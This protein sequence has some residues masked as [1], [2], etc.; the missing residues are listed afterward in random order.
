M[1]LTEINIEPKVQPNSWD[2]YQML[3]PYTYSEDT[4]FDDLTGHLL[5]VL[6]VGGHERLNRRCLRFLLTEIVRVHRIDPEMCL[7]YRRHEK[8]WALL[9]GPIY[10]S[11]L[12]YNPL[13]I[14]HKCI[15]FID[16]MIA[17]GFLQHKTGFYDTFRRISR[18]SRIKPTET[19]IEGFLKA[20]GVENI[21]V[22]E[23]HL[24]PV[25][26]LKDHN[27]QLIPYD[28]NLVRDE[29][30]VLKQYNALLEDTVISTMLL[31]EK[32]RHFQK[33]VYRV[34]N[35]GSFKFGGR[36][37]GGW[38]MNCKSPF[39]KYI[40]LNT[41]PTIELDYQAQ[42]LN[43]L[44]SLEGEGYNPLTNGD[45]YVIE[46]VDRKLVKKIFLTA[47]NADDEKKGWQA[48]KTDLQFN[49]PQQL[50]EVVN[51]LSQYRQVLD[52]IKVKHPLVTSYFHSGIGLKLQNIDSEIANFILKEAVS[53]R[54]PILGVHDSFIVEDHNKGLLKD[55]M[56]G[57]YEELNISPIPAVC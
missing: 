46:G 35:N 23:S 33:F 11:E 9:N 20:W 12:S 26:E 17:K 25:I 30:E 6:D 24:R 43:L 45:P 32:H 57:A 10:N 14:S 50:L 19:F 52:C 2:Y 54:I 21:L 29:V 3:S 4:R 13:R 40:L 36:F 37:A 28:E 38:W 55:W 42:H 16:A 48:L 7:G 39:R 27:K 31:P 34:F 49:G 53:R 47:L 22:Q 15:A 18:T 8:W 44:Y 5:Q 41:N 1:P 51:T 56:I